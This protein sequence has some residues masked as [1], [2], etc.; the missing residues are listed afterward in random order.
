MFF[1]W[2]CWFYNTKV[3]SSKILKICIC[4]KPIRPLGGNIVS[5]HIAYNIII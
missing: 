5:D 1:F 3:V 2:D 4:L